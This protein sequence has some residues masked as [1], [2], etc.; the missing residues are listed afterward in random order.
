[1]RMVIVCTRSERATIYF[2]SNKTWIARPRGKHAKLD[3]KLAENCLEKCEA[4]IKKDTT[5][6]ISAL[7]EIISMYS[8]GQ[9]VGVIGNKN[10]SKLLTKLSERLSNKICKLNTTKAGHDPGQEH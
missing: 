9:E 2:P 4:S 5:G 10:L 1:M 6:V 3:R 7:R 8:D